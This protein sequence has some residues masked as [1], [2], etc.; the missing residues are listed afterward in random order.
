MSTH[1]NETRKEESIL[2]RFGHGRTL[3][4]TQLLNQSLRTLDVLLLRKASD[5][6]IFTNL[7]IP[8]SDRQLSGCLATDERPMI[9]GQTSADI[10]IEMLA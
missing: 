3:T 6:P 8:I 1:T 9:D 7:Q 5:L 2:P 10:F 4:P